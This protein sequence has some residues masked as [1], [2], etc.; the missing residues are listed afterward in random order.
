MFHLE[1]PSS[2]PLSPVWF[3]SGISFFSKLFYPPSNTA[4]W[5]TWHSVSLQ[6][7]PHQALLVLSPKHLSGPSMSL[8]FP[9]PLNSNTV[10]SSLEDHP[11][12]WPAISNTTNG[13][14]KMQILSYDLQ[15]NI[16]EGLPIARFSLLDKTKI[17]N[18]NCL[19][20]PMTGL[21]TPSPRL[22]PLLPLPSSPHWPSCRCP[23]PKA[24]P[25]GCCKCGS[26][27]PTPTSCCS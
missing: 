9:C 12:S 11:C 27:H 24:A 26:L 19:G 21:P 17:L 10:T 22:R 18:K 5:K 3:F 8:P 25:P 6:P 14:S 2:S 1:L 15:L 16:L 20:L 7:A 4:G 23:R 13:S